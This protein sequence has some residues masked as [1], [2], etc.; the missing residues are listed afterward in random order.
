MARDIQIYLNN[1]FS[2]HDLGRK[3]IGVA[4]SGGRDSVALAYALKQGGY[5]IVAI[6]VEHGIRGESSVKDSEF[7]KDFCQK[8][9]IKLYAYK[10]DVPSFCESE[11]YT[12]EQGARLLRY[13]V[14]DRA[15]KDGICEV[16][17]LAH[18]L[19]D[20]AETVFMRI[21]RGTGVSG[22]QGMSEVRDNYIRPLLNCPREEIERYIEDCGLE[23]VDDE[24]NFDCDYTRNYL[25]KEL[26][27]LKEKFP[28]ICRSFA[29]LSQNAKEEE[30]FIEK[31]ISSI[32]IIGDESRVKIENMQDDFIAKRLVLKAINALGVRQDIES[33]HYPLIFALKDA[34]NGKKINLTHEICAHKDGD[35]IVFSKGNSDENLEEI[36]FELG[37]N[38]ALKI[39][40]ERVSIEEF[41]SATRGEGVLFA[42]MDKIPQDAVLRNRKEGDFINKFGGGTKS[43]GDF[44][45]DK[46]VP[47]RKRDA[48]KV[49]AFGSEVFAVFG[50]EISQKV[51]VSE[52][53]KR[54]VKLTLI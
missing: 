1:F 21:L 35:F 27:A 20:Q 37:R 45:T 19:D 49:I 25:R 43:L 51:A 47:L 48:L 6:N 9:D 31:H 46:K 30:S 33:R 36:P 3:K 40:V 17:A 22:L 34:E 2:K 23:Y 52:D 18:H 10:V 12:I 8:Y 14:F 39:S 13:D 16:I 5:D 15:I 53:S 44:L 32:E 11:G 24:S 41:K 4:L 54:V 38:D 28:Q 29:R 26:T 7:V 50:V 42:D